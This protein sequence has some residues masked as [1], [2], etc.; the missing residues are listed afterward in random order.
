MFHRLYLLIG[1][2]ALVAF[3]IGQYRGKSPFD[4]FANTASS[5]PRSGSHTFHK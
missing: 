5:A 2:I 3:S 4:V 1:I